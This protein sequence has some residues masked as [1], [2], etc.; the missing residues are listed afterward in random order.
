MDNGGSIIF[1]K[2]VVLMMICMIIN[3]IFLIVYNVLVV[4]GIVFILIV[5]CFFMFFIL[6][7]RFF[8]DCISIL[9]CFCKFI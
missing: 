8:N 1:V 2:D 4:V 7:L 5:F 9:V 3:G 6:V